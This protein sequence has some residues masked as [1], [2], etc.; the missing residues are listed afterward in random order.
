VQSI[1]GI[2][3]GIGTDL[4][5]VFFAKQTADRLFDNDYVWSVLAAG[6]HQ[7]PFITQAAMLGGNGRVGMEDSLYLGRGTLASSNAEQVRK[8]RSILEELG[9][10]IAS[11]AEARQTLA[12]KAATGSTFSRLTNDN[13][14]AA[15]AWF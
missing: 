9:H 5:N 1:F 4:E 13:K 11:P 6:R 10:A 14:P 2:L 8:I 7:M 3:G 15:E 12:L